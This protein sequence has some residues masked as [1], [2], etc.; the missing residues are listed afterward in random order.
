MPALRQSLRRARVWLVLTAVVGVGAV[1][2]WTRPAE[3]QVSVALYDRGLIAPYQA[4]VRPVLAPLVRCRFVPTCS[5]YSREAVRVH[6]F[7]KGLWLSAKRVARCLPS[8][9]PGTEDPVPPRG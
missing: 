9:K 3:R 2:D 8:V 6:G 1:A 4:F 7:A 5:D